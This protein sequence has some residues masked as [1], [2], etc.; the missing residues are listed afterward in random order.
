M[1]W[2]L[3]RMEVLIRMGALIRIGAL[4][5]MGV[6]INKNTFESG[7]FLEG[8]RLIESLW[9]V[10]LNSRTES[11]V[12]YCFIVSVDQ[13]LTHHYTEKLLFLRLC[14]RN[15]KECTRKG[16]NCINA[17]LYVS[18]CYVLMYCNF[19]HKVVVPTATKMNE[20]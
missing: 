12:L 8:G 16:K 2:A 3:I 11:C 6:L 9:W 14:F 20:T 15:A 1:N 19:C 10:M 17:L 7:R 18:T 13:I 5:E 4:I